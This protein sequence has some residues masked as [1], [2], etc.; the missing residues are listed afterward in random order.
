MSEQKVLFLEKA[1]G[2][3]IVSKAPIPKPG[4]G[5]LLVSVKASALNPA[6]CLVQDYGL[7]VEKFPAIL[8]SDIAGD[9]VEVG[10]GV[11]GF[12]KGDKVFYHG[13]M[14]SEMAGYQEYSLTA[15]DL[16]AKIPPNIDYAQAA[17]LPVAFNTSAIG[18][19]SAQPAGA[20]LNP[21]FDLK[22]NYGG[23]SA[24]VVGGSTSVG[25]YAI[26]LFR[27][28]GYSTII[29]YASARHTDFLK[30]LG[31]THVIDRGEIA[32]G[33]LAEAVKKIATAPLKI[34]YNAIG[35]AE[36]RSA[37]VDSIV[38]GGQVADV[39]PMEAKDPGNGKRVFGIFGTPHH[40][41]NRDFGVVLCKTLPKLLQDGLIVPNRMEKLPHGF[42]GVEE[43][44][45]RLRT[46]QVS[47]IKL[48]VIPQETA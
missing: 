8:G 42:A 1:Q 11:E 12:S 24:L 36:C 45:K 32:I 19:L 48:F 37:C 28:L 21:T 31:A 10:E 22:V 33:N 7:F 38:E 26:Q 40:P 44:I 6:E 18:L 2:S 16:A 25:Q 29:T 39:N 13:Y 47:G 23:E 17:S 3:F 4:P 43:G 30:S 15:A 14:G 46:K 5:Q 41:A 34:A 35:D 27:L 20:G 9:V